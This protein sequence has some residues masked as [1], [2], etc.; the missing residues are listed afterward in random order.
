MPSL[1]ERLARGDDSAFAE[2]YDACA[3]GLHR[4]AAARLGSSE[5]AGD[6]VQTAFLRAVKSRRRFRGVE[7]PA[8]YLFQIGRNEIAR[9]AAQRTR[10]RE[11][12]LVDAAALAADAKPA[13]G[14]EAATALKRLSAEDREIVELKIYAGLTFAE[15]AAAVERPAATVATR[16]RRALESLRG[17]LEKQ[18]R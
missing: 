5:A 1:A 3:D 7:N 4:Y 17:W 9:A 8:G 10:R 13:S 6:V 11:E 14:E 2:L 18:M 16:Y 15:I 12:P